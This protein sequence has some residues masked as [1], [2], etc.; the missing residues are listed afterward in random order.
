VISEA[1]LP[2]HIPKEAYT[3]PQQ[4][5]VGPELNETQKRSDRS[6]QFKTYGGMNLKIAASPVLANS[7]SS[8]KFDLFQGKLNFVN[9]NKNKQQIGTLEIRIRIMR[10]IRIMRMSNC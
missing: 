2:C 7:E 10:I 3:L 5:R 6:K 4:K 9:V 8:H 1:G